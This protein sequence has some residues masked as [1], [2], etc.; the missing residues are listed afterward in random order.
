MSTKQRKKIIGVFTSGQLVPSPKS[1]EAC[2]YEHAQELA[3]DDPG[4]LKKIYKKLSFERLGEIRS[5]PPEKR[6]ACLCSRE[7]L[8]NSEA[9]SSIRLSCVKKREFKALMSTGGIQS[10]KIICRNQKC[11]KNSVTYFTSQM[12]S[13]DEGS[14]ACYICTAC[15]CSW[16]E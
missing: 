6:M 7:V 15:G 10:G 12:N 16:K 2:I 11:K 5:L 4:A 9:Y 14:K 8:W 13:C 1:A 3:G